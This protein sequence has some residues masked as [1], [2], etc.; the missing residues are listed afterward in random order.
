MSGNSI[1]VSTTDSA[2][3]VKEALESG[4][5]RVNGPIA[6]ET[7]VKATEQPTDTQDVEEGEEVVDTP[8]KGAVET[9]ESLKARIKRM[10]F[11]Q[12]R[13]IDTAE[14]IR[15]QNQTLLKRLEE[16]EKATGKTAEPAEEQLPKFDKPEPSLEDAE[17][18]DQ[19]AKDHAKWVEEKVR[20]ELTQEIESREKKRE[21]STAQTQAQQQAQ[22]LQQEHD[23]RIAKF[24]ETH[25]DFYEVA[26]AA[27]EA[28]VPLSP[29]MLTH[30]MNS[31][32]G[33]AILYHL[34]KPENHKLATEIAKLPQ[35]PA[36]VRL[37]RLEA[38][39]EAEAENSTA[40][41]DGA[42]G[43]DENAQPKRPL[44]TATGQQQTKSFRP[45]APIA[46]TGGKNTKDPSKMSAHEYRKWREG[47]GGR[48]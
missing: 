16:L 41:G 18:L 8:R 11:E 21:T 32:L 3:Q 34:A 19:W 15:A 43:G 24:A 1:I 2:D 45:P 13:I 37:G 9:V 31:E 40:T 47:G 14:G 12:H 10:S 23:A 36:W 44:A 48:R 39:L 22:Q 25:A 38:K 6:T 46:G 27:V 35:G 4:E 42:Q 7:E 20:F 26:E 17:T 5:T 33:P 29:P 30:V 28:G